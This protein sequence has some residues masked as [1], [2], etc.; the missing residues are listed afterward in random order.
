MLFFTAKEEFAM[1]SNGE[2]KQRARKAG[3]EKGPDV[4]VPTMAED[5][6][7]L[8]PCTTKPVHTQESIL[9]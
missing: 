4:T 7:P 6:G 2:E 1:A 8:G 9:F 3:E 5:T